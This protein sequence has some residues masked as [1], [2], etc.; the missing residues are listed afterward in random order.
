MTNASKAE[1]ID[2]TLI[3]LTCENGGLSKCETC[4]NVWSSISLLPVGEVRA[5]AASYISNPKFP[6]MAICNNARITIT[7]VRWLLRTSI[8]QKNRSSFS[9]CSES[10]STRSITQKWNDGALAWFG[11][12][13]R[14][15]QQWSL[16]LTLTA[17]SS[18]HA[19]NGNKKWLGWIHARHKII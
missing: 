9:T 16:I 6:R 1:H 4:K 2:S 5:N 19:G 18:F 10:S 11:R 15:K 3:R 14:R 12:V 13:G 8:T 7:C 17:P